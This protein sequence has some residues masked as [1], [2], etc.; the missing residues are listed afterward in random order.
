[1]FGFWKILKKWKEKVFKKIIFLFQNSQKKGQEQ[2]IKEKR[3]RNVTNFP[4]LF[5]QIKVRKAVYFII[6]YL[7]FS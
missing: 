4:S 3:R 1:M 7:F 5:P 2:N 6:I